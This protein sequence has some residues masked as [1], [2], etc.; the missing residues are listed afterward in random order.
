MRLLLA[1]AALCLVNAAAEAACTKP[2]GRYV[3]T[4]AGISVTTSGVTTN[5]GSAAISL[6]I[7]SSGSG[8]IT[9]AG[10]TVQ[11]GGRY[12]QTSSFTSTFDSTT[13]IGTVT[14]NIGTQFIFTSADSGKVLSFTYYKNDNLVVLYSVTLIKA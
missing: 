9:E 13:C 2:S 14:T 11:S 4:G 1:A 7:A 6:N 12:S 10:K 3:G 5:L 8:T